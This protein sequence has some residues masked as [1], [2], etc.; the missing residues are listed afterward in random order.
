M[1]NVSMMRTIFMAI[2]LL[3]CTAT[4]VYASMFELET[5][6]I[7]TINDDPTVYDS[8]MA[9]R[10]ISVIGNL[11]ELTKQ[12]AIL[13]DNNDSLK[14]DIAR[15]ELFDGFNVS[16][17]VLV[18]G[19]FIYNPLGDSTFTPNYVLRYPTVDMGLVNISDVNADQ[20]HHNGKYITVIGNLSK[21]EMSMGRYTAIIKDDEGNSMK[22]FY[23]GSTELN[24]GAIVK[25]F[26]LYN[27]NI[28]HSEN[29]ATN[30]SPLSLTTLVPG[31]SSILGALAIIS[32]ALL[33]KSKER[34]D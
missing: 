34:N 17:Q 6:A 13:T 30:K 29:M 11:S 4:T 8:T 21:L 15:M 27:G 24:T 18:T 20:S 9:Y 14:I 12:S 33:L 22:I 1:L 3:S 19:E 5:V 31:F 28:L 2:L 25:V 10:K 16:E 32:I 7:S 23:Y 26:G